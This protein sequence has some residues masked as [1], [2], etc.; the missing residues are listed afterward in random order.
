VLAGRN[1]AQVAAEILA[2]S[3]LDEESQND[4]HERR[5]LVPRE[6]RRKGGI[7]MAEGR[8]LTTRDA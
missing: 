3:R 7:T 8:G 2:S 6:V 4:A 5:S 1:L